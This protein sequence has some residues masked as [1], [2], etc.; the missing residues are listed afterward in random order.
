[1][2]DRKSSPSTDALLSALASEYRRAVLSS[3]NRTDADGM[4]VP[5]L[6]NKVAQLVHDVE[7]PTDE[8][9]HRTA[10][11]LHHIH[12][13]KLEGAGMLVYEREREQVVDVTG[14]CP[15]ELLTAV[16]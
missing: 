15:E 14:T 3:L 8:Q 1:M 4:A 2:S 16:L 13:P 12:L 10:M 5:E 11:F 6:V 7:E 9:R